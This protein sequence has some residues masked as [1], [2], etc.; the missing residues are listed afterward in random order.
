M[1]R[2]IVAAVLA[3]LLALLPA[4]GAE[5]LAYTSIAV[6]GT[7]GVVGDSYAA[8]ALHLEDESLWLAESKSWPQILGRKNGVQVTNYCIP[9]IDTEGFLNT[10]GG[11]R[12][13]LEDEPKELYLLNLGINDFH[14]G[15]DYLGTPEDMDT[16]ANTF[17]GN[18]AAIIRAIQARAPGA[19]LI[20]LSVAS[21]REDSRAAMNPAI[22]T[23]A[24]HCGV[25]YICLQDDP[26]FTS[27]FYIDNMVSQHPVAITCAG[28]AEAI[29]RLVERCVVENAAY[30]RYITGAPGTAHGAQ[31]PA[32]Q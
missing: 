25:P 3:V 32:G 31:T 13:L 26:F 15:E 8:G 4:A 14:R 16:G 1:K 24:E 29:Q 30:F 9:G 12:R 23:L 28:M 5:D 22:Q 20:L 19:C 11:L 18:Y 21:A 17:Y 27:D 10:P 2:P 6:F 7:I